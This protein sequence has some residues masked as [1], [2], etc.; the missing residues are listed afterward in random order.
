MAV[1]ESER[2]YLG[3]YCMSFGVLLQNDGNTFSLHFIIQLHK[4][5][6]DDLLEWPF[7][8][9]I[10]LGIVRH[11]TSKFRRIDFQPGLERLECFFKADCIQ[12]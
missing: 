9:K 6:L 12:Q 10:R 5:D 11:E 3:G 1:R 4:G 8:H 7:Q 2:V